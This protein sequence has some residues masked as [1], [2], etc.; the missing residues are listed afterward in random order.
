MRPAP[1]PAPEPDAL[2]A[3]PVDLARRTRV[4][5]LT[6]RAGGRR[7][8]GAPRTGGDVDLEEV[9]IRAGA[10]AVEAVTVADPVAALL[11]A[12]AD[13]TL[14]SVGVGPTA[15]D[16]GTSDAGGPDAVAVLDA[17]LDAAVGRGS[18]DVHLEPVPAG[19]RVRLR[20]DGD[21][22][23]L[24][25]VP[26]ELRDAVVARVKVRA[27]LDVAERRAPQAGRLVHPPPPGMVD[28]RVAPLP[29]RP[30]ERVTLRLLPRGEVADLDALGLPDEVGRALVAAGGATDG[31]VVVCGPTGSGKTTTLHALLARIALGARAVM[32]IEDP[33]ERE[34]AGTSQTQV[35]PAAGLGFATGLRHLLRHDPDVLLVGEVRD[36]ETAALAVEAA[37]TGHLVLTSLHAVDAP[38]AL[39][40]FGDLGLPPARV[41][42]V[43][44]LV[45]AQRLL[46]LPCPAC[47]G[48]TGCR[49]C[50]GTGARGRTAVAEALPFDAALRAGVLG[51]AD[52][53]AARA[54]LHAG[55]RPRLREVALARA[56]E[57]R[58]RPLDAF[59]STPEPPG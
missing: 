59:A 15:S 1:P 39:D 54:T 38:S 58:A 14:R 49:D 28:V 55:C 17:V 45:V 36:A 20:R 23:V 27:D 35:D 8:G 47:T 5:P 9:R 10:V 42:P 56:A 50:D 12:H 13:R 37:R 53:T 18:S 40:R 32:T 26:A 22:H 11:V 43:L 57:G 48:G 52:A 7:G 34:V 19:L 51:A 24:G 41:L 31:L 4:L 30:R 2:A 25:V 6:L 33:V 3:V 44:R 46:A 21:L 29:A 16:T